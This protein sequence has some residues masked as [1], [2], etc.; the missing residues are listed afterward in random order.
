M[1]TL[2]SYLDSVTLSDVVILGESSSRVFATGGK[3]KTPDGLL[4]NKLTI[5]KE[6][7]ADVYRFTSNYEN[8]M[9]KIQVDI[10][11]IYRREIDLELSEQVQLQ[12]AS[13]VAIMVAY[14]YIRQAIWAAAARLGV[15][16][17]VLGILKRG[18]AQFQKE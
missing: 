1:T 2:E 15:P 18:Q 14:P 11:V 7:D 13:E 17:P 16:K 3:E 9:S 12:F 8:P 10:G 6:T 4:Q 5:H